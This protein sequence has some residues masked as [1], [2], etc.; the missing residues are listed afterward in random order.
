MGIFNAYTRDISFRKIIVQQ[1]YVLFKNLIV[2]CRYRKN[3][4]FKTYAFKFLKSSI[5]IQFTNSKFMEK[6]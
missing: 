5:L 3:K 1:I 4:L 6:N 2:N